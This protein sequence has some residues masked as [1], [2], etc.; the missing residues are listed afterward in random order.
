MAL[1]A[2]LQCLYTVLYIGLYSY[3]PVGL[4]AMSMHRALY[5]SYGLYSCGLHSYGPVGLIAMSI[6]RVLYSYGLYSRLPAMMYFLTDRATSNWPVPKPPL[7]STAE[8]LIWL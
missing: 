1:L 7:E 5:N 8:Y 3:G 2:R 6:H 4:I